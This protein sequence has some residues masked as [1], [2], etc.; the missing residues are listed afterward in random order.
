MSSQQQ[1][2]FVE[3][4]DLSIR[5]IEIYRYLVPDHKTELSVQDFLHKWANRI[6]LDALEEYDRAQLLREVA[7]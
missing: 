2:P 1:D 5:G 6:E 3:E 4:E 7:R